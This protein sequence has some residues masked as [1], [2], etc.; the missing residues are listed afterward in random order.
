MRLL[1]V[2]LFLTVFLS[3]SDKKKEEKSAIENFDKID[4]IQKELKL[5]KSNL[6]VKKVELPFDLEQ[7]DKLANLNEEEYLKT[8]PKLKD[9]KL[10]EIKKIISESSDGDNADEIF[11]INNGGLTFDSF[12]YCTY[13]DSDSQTLINVKNNK[14]IAK[15]AIG[16]AMP[17]NETYQSFVIN[18]DLTIDVY[19]VN[20]NSRSKKILERHQIKQDGFIV[21]VK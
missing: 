19:D 17:D 1:I 2:I 13:G 15:E 3:C 10:L 5:D 14:I 4:N 21:K 11:Q 6:S 9:S 20:Y 8:Y 7:K 18:K 16:Y 12:V